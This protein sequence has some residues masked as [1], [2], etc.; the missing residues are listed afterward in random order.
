[1]VIGVAGLPI[2]FA[3]IP[4]LSVVFW[5]LALLLNATLLHHKVL[6]KD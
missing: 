1:M 4:W 6:A 5:S 2:A 3:G